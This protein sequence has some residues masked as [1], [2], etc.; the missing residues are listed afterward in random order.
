MSEATI[1]TRAP[2][3]EVLLD[4][5]V[6]LPN[7]FRID[8]LLKCQ[9]K[10]KSDYPDKRK[11]TF[12]TLH[13]TFGKEVSSSASMRPAGFIFSSTDKRQLFQAAVDGFTFNRLAPYQGWESFIKES[14]RLW[15]VY[16]SIAHPQH[17]YKRIAIRTINKFEFPSP[18]VN[19]E[20]YFRT[21]IEVSRDLPQN[22]HGFFMQFNLPVKEIESNVII[23]QTDAQSSKP[24]FFSI[25]LDIDLV[26]TANLPTG[27]DIWSMLEIFRV[28]KNKLFNDCLTQAGKDMIL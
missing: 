25:V 2:I 7:D 8:K 11:K 15:E 1:Y 14:K 18:M 9:Q 27:T 22:L 6:D 13:A 16:R 12:G 19:M 5:K 23:S 20:T 4:I 21:Y 3:V 17:G 26:R 24:G 10:V 28:W